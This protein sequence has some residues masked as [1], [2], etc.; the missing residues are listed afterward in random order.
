MNPVEAHWF[1]LPP[2]RDQDA[3]RLA[4]RRHAEDQGLSVV[5]V[6]T[7]EEEVGSEIVLSSDLDRI[8][9]MGANAE[10]TTVLDLPAFMDLASCSDSDRPLRVLD[11]SRKIVAARNFEGSLTSPAETLPYPFSQMTGVVGDLRPATAVEERFQEALAFVGQGAARWAPEIFQ[12]TPGP[13]GAE[14]PGVL[15][16][17]G[18]PRFLVF[19]PYMFLP[20]GVWRITARMGF[21]VDAGARPYQIQWGDSLDYVFHDF[22][23]GQS[24]VF[25]ITLEREWKT[26]AASEIRLMLV[27]GAFHGRLSWLGATVSRVDQ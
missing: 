13:E 22:T 9:P 7:G 24:G 16:I 17:T 5:E 12:Y 27:E 8:R 18:R 11:L 6:V 1:V 25:E 23:P 10:N 20:R 26:H 21:D 14:Q 3:W 2:S 4:M 19:G 15:D